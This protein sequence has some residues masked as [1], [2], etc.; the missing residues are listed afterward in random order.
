MHAWPGEVSFAHNGVL[1]LDELP[2]FDPRVLEALREPL[3]NG[4]IAVSRLAM[5]AEY[6]A[7]FA[8]VAAMNPC[9]CGYLGDTRGRCRCTPPQ[10][11]RYRTRISGPL[12]DR[13][14]L[15][16]EVPAVADDELA[17]ATESGP[18]S[19]AVAASVERAR[20]R[21]LARAGKLNAHLTA[22]ELDEF[23]RLEPTG[24]RL[25]W[26][27]RARFGMSAR[28]CHRVLRVARTIADMDAAEIIGR[29]HVGEAL[30]LRRALE[31][32]DRS[33]G[34]R[35]MRQRAGGARRFKPSA[36]RSPR[37]GARRARPGTIRRPGR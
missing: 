16:V 2:E 37:A 5:Q 34:Q 13:I 27:S 10:I 20:A 14:D 24:E 12:L 3:E 35:A 19:A 6:P 28:S 29:E 25:L 36:E 26:Q 9:P 21:Q 7:R 11:A 32:S 33:A 22:R 18:D 23:C 8:L 31:Q 15:R 4:V 17:S 30:Q 1:F